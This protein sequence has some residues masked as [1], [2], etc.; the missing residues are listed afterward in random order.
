VGHQHS[1]VSRNR[2]KPSLVLSPHTKLTEHGVCG[3]IA[4]K[5][6]PI[7]TADTID[8]LVFTLGAYSLAFFNLDFFGI[9]D[10]ND[11]KDGV[12]DRN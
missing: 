6:H 8:T 10:F 4:I 11:L 7:G 3:W 1:S 2:F 9:T 5:T 12:I